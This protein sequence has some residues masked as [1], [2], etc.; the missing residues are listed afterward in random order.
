MF[1]E[2][3]VGL[4]EKGEFIEWVRLSAVLDTFPNFKYAAVS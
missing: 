4:W 2:I 1:D 3:Q